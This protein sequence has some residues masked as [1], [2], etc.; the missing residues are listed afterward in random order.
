[1]KAAIVFD[2]EFVCLEGSQ[3]RYWCAAHDPDPVIAQI[4]AVKLGLEDDFP[5]LDTFMAY[6]VPKDR[7]G[8]R[9]L[10]DPF[11]TKLT[12]I[13]NEDIEK[14]GI[15]LPQAL[16]DLDQF[17]EGARFWSWGKDELNMV[18]IS[19]YVAGVKP[20]IPAIRFDN[21]VKLLLSAGMPFEDLARTPSN[22][23]SEYY[24]VDHPPLRGHNARDDALS[25]A[26]TLQHLLRLQKLDA[27]AFGSS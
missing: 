2:C 20:P 13:S 9:Y 21:A 7:F 5:I 4:G 10:L 12:G 24:G 23:L 15:S 25:V 16:A 17:S 14:H 27:S 8:Q 22:K 18:A 19:C 11:F 3:R 6:V 1:M 26:Y